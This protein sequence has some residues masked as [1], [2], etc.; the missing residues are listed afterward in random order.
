MG[1]TTCYSTLQ[2]LDGGPGTQLRTGPKHLH[3]I[4]SRDILGLS[5]GSIVTSEEGPIKDG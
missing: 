5:V 2:T 3:G 1:P 4:G